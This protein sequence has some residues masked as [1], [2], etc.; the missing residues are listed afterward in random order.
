M[1]AEFPQRVENRV[2][3]RIT[4]NRTERQSEA[5]IWSSACRAVIMPGGHF[6]SFRIAGASVDVAC[7]VGCEG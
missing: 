3:A 1:G 7:D 6:L 5:A 4:E 2:E